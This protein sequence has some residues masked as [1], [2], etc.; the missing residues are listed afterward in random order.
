MLLVHLLSSDPGTFVYHLLVLLV[1][2]AMAV[3][4]LIGWRHTHN[5]HHRRI[6]WAFAGLLVLR[7]LLL[8]GKPLGLAV[9]A[10][11]LEGMKVTSL[12]LLGWAFLG[13]LLNRRDRRWYLLG[14]LG[15]TLLCV[16]MFLPGWR[17]TLSRTPDLLYSAFWQQTIW[18][19][20]SMLLALIPA[21]IPL[22]RQRWEKQWLPMSGFG[23]LFLGFT[24]LCVS[25]LL[26]EVGWFD[27]GVFAHTLIGAGR[28]IN[29]LGYPLFAIAVYRMALQDM[30]AYYQELQVASE[31]TLRR[32]L[33]LHFLVRAGQVVGES[34]D[35]DIILP[36]VVEN[37]AM[38]LDADRCAILL[39]N[40]DEPG[41]AQL[42]GQYAPFRRAQHAADVAPTFS[43]AELPTLGHVM[44]RRQQL[45]LNAEADNPRLRALYG[46]LGGH[47]AGPTIVQPL[48]HQDS[49]L[50]VLVVGNDVSRRTF[51]SNE[52]RLCESIAL[53]IAAAI[54]NVRLYLDL[55]ARARQLAE[56]LQSEEEDA[57]R[58]AAILESVA[59]G[60]IVGDREGLITSVNVAA[61][62][63][64]GIPRQTI[65]GHSLERLDHITWAP[66][67]NWELMVRSGIPLQTVFELGGKVVNVN[68]APVL[69]P[70]GERLGIVAIL[71]DVTSE[72]EAERAKS[73]FIIAVSRRLR[74]PL[75]AIR[76]YTEALSSGVAGTMNEAQSHFL[77]IIRDNALRTVSL[78]GNLI[79]VAQM[80]KGFLKLEYGETDLHLI[81]GDVV[82]SFQSQLEARQ[83]EVRLELDD[84]LPMVEADPARV[85]QILDNLV[86]NAIK[87][88][89]PGGRITIGARLLCDEGEQAT[90]CALWVSDT[91]IGISPEEQARIWERFYR[92]S[93]PLATEAGGLGV[94]LSIVKSLVE[95]HG[96]RV[97]L[98]STPGVGSTFT[99]LLP[100]NRAPPIDG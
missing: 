60:V 62:R 6:L 87:F 70:A 5:P 78:A 74:T 47:E 100:V 37:I 92:P 79:A 3:I 96:G 20:M 44:Q 39:T 76:G 91:G 49:I 33:E 51:G 83:L 18:H 69:T 58:R 1:L 66:A 46:L 22:R 53:Q 59:E 8:L 57:Y 24:T 31:G 4:A 12:T 95:A 93:N 36:Q 40:P 41:T 45:I 11:L 10:P 48:L 42:A 25:S 2:E 16:V 21:L 54:E 80:E 81:V 72:T 19:T 52:G 85:R 13:R 14:C 29:L 55:K 77:R 34:L 64:L 32:T 89:Y 67:V 43:L 15:A 7:I 63:I 94:G 82:P 23:I 88:A 71:R 9:I 38:A 97:W 65:L 56:S 35:L 98:E 84:D 50:G 75:T 73:E 28:F 26:L 99:V 61:E 27:S 86:S 90:V 68:A 30:R 17:R